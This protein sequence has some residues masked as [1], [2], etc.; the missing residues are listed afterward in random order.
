M[1][2]TITGIL[3]SATASVQRTETFRT[4][5]FVLKVSENVNGTVYDNYIQFQLVNN[6]CE[7]LDN[8][9]P[10][11]LVQVTYN[12][13]GNLWTTPEGEQK[14]ITNLNAWRIEPA[15][16]QQAPAPAA[17]WGQPNAAPAQAW[18]QPQPQT[19]EAQGTF[20]TAT[21]QQAWGQPSAAPE[22]T[23]E[24]KLPF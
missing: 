19:Q 2:T 1:N 10:N 6:N 20:P 12:L 13:R 15:A 3:F 22:Q 18:R 17:A 14:C 11:Q 21:P 4:R 5:S 7:I 8:F 23:Q 9:Q 16:Q 24:Q